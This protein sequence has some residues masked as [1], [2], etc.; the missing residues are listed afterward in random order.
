MINICIP[1]CWAQ[2]DNRVSD[3][4]TSLRNW[5][6]YAQS[7]VGEDG[8]VLS[9][10]GAQNSFRGTSLM[11]QLVLG[12]HI[13]LIDSSSLL[14]LNQIAEYLNTQT[15]YKI[16]ELDSST[17]TNDDILM[18]NAVDDFLV[19]HY[20]LTNSAQSREN[21]LKITDYLTQQL[22]W[23]TLNSRLFTLTNILRI[24]K[25]TGGSILKLD[26]EEAISDILDHQ[27]EF[28]DYSLID[29][30]NFPISLNILSTLYTAA[31][32]SK[33]NTPTEV[34]ALWEVYK[35]YTLTELETIPTTP[36]YYSTNLL[37][38]SSLVE[39]L[40]VSQDP[41]VLS[42]AQNLTSK[43]LSI[44][45]SGDRIIRQPF[46]P[47]EIY[48]Y[49]PALTYSKIVMDSTNE[50]TIWKIDLKLPSL[51]NRLSAHSQSNLAEQ[52][53]SKRNLALNKILQP[54]NLSL[55]EVG[56]LPTQNFVDYLEKTAF[57]SE[58]LARTR[59][60]EQIPSDLLP[61]QP[62]NIPISLIVSA[63]IMISVGFLYTRGLLFKKKE[64][65]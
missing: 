25:L 43:L 62:I 11:G 39:S 44:W 48:P 37:Y 64:D 32:Q 34:I 8:Q 57:V 7:N 45:Q 52:Y 60:K 51:I 46:T 28:I 53:Q 55:Y 35:N 10:Y 18:I 33:V 20:A 40:D 65:D 17:M 2:Q 61:Q 13:G 15:P 14:L 21:L 26:V 59:L 63:T 4:E 38:L 42:A 1:Q 24:E 50:V 41:L 12:T 58:Y 27:F 6:I 29:P 19:G 3:A 49:D 23:S 16:L 54:D 9:S 36:K 31:L 22:G 5:L 47:F 56:T 30:I